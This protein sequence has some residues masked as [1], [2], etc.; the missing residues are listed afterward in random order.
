MNNNQNEMK[1]YGHHSSGRSTMKRILFGFFLIGGGLI[2]LGANLGFV[3]E[4]VREYVISWQALIIA[5]G[6]VTMVGNKSGLWFSLILIFTGSLFLFAKY[7]DLPVDAEL[8]FWPI[9][10]IFVGL[11]ILTKI[12]QAH[13]FRQRVNKEQISGDIIDDTNVFGGNKINVTS[14]N[15]QGG[16]VTCVFGGSELN[17]THAELQ[18]GDT[19]IEINCVFGGVKFIVPADWDVVTDVTG[20]LGGMSD[21]RQIVTT[22]HVD[23]TRRLIIKGN[24]VF[25]GGELESVVRK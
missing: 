17:F 23:M 8:I 12:G 4:V 18:E 25:G 1:T 5:I 19:T 3:P 13:K 7:N 2:W 14:N 10:L 24:C 9:V 21:K 15:F 11:G 22:H 16:Q 6:L 20:V